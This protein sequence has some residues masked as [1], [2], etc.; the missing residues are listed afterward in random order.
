MIHIA[1]R[2]LLALAFCTS[3]VVA[4]EI[5]PK[6]LVDVTAVGSESRLVP[7]GPDVTVTRATG[8]TAGLDVAIAP[9]GSAFPGVKLLPTEGAATWDLSKYGHVESKITNT[10]SDVLV[11]NLRVDNAGT[12]ADR[13]FNT[14][15]L[16]IQPGKTAVVTVIFGFQY[17]FSP[18]YALKPDAVSAVLLFTGKSEKPQSFRVESLM[19]AGPPGEKPTSAANVAR[20]KPKGGVILGQGVTINAAKQLEAKAGAVATVDGSAVVVTIPKGVVNTVTVGYKPASGKWHLGDASE[21]RVTIRNTGKSPVTPTAQLDSDVESTA[22]VSAGEIEP[23]AEKEVVIPFTAQKSWIGVPTAERKGNHDSVKGTGT[24]YASDKTNALRITADRPKGV[25]AQFR[26][27][28]AIATSS[29]MVLAD[30]VGKRPP[31][32]E[33]TWT[34]TFDDDF[35]GAAID[36]KK[37]NNF[38]PNHW[39]KVSHWSRKN[40]IVSDGVAKIRAE[41]KTGF[42][43]DDPNGKQTHQVA[44]YLDT[45]DLFRQRYGYFETRTKLPTAPGLWPAFW[46]MPDR[47]PNT[48]EASPGSKAKRSETG[49]YG[50]E[51]D[52]LEHLTIWGKHRYNIAMHWDNYGPEH[53]AT[54][55]GKLY[56]LPDKDGF[57]TTGLL[58]LPGQAVFYCNGIEV[59]RWE[60]P[61][62]SKVPGYMMFTLPV[63]GWDGNVSDGTGFPDDF[64]IDY[65][66]VWQRDDL[67]KIPLDPAIPAN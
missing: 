38:G 33:G 64:V 43:N 51:F 24:Q 58:W 13:A 29:T 16:K 21:V 52:I 49:N 41:R 15:I 56:V 9:N 1:L 62:V 31:V 47:G 66:R 6:P 65:V 17:G 3:L 59:G 54:G 55:S 8:D 2:T 37:W 42:H 18:G 23:G 22:V 14:E 4:Q 39:D 35:D 50:M 7:S 19:S 34:K 5:P 11:M 20:V 61:R 25:E 27:E 26:I 57:I 48:P 30:W 12:A 63:G 67:A 53:K 28:S 36:L 60:D 10:G 32:T 45:F 44:G 40:T 46:L